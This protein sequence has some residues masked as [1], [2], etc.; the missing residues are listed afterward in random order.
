MHTILIITAVLT[1]AYSHYWPPY[2]G[3]N[4]G[5]YVAN[6]DR[7]VTWQNS[8]AACPPQWPL[9]TQFV[10]ADDPVHVWT[11]VDRGTLVQHTADRRPIL[12]LMERHPRH[13]HKAPIVVWVVET[14]QSPHRMN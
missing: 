10:L 9:G 4:G 7:A 14:M 11:C 5:A 1:A 12:D 13:H 6:G 8:G 3:L 2:G